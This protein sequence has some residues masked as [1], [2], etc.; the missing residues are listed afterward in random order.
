MDNS[1][2]HRQFVEVIRGSKVSKN[3][4]VLHERMDE[5]GKIDECS[6]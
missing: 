1:K 5:H 4:Q 6:R 2:K 3:L